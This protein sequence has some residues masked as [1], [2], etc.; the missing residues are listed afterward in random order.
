MKIE[1]LTLEAVLPLIR[2]K[3]TTAKKSGGK[4]STRS[5]GTK[6]SGKATSA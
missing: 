3:L 4:K 1:D 2:D 5:G 6:R